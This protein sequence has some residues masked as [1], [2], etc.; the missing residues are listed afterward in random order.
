MDYKK[1]T[2][3][4]IDP[5]LLA[6]KA[7]LLTHFRGECDRTHATYFQDKCH[8]YCTSGATLHQ[9]AIS[10]VNRKLDDNR[11]IVYL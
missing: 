4:V 7:S 6:F 11:P 10:N 1:I 9:W 2:S 8:V 3:T 5:M